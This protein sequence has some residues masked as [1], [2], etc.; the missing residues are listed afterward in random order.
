MRASNEFSAAKI[1]AASQKAKPKVISKFFIP[2]SPDSYRRASS[3]SPAE[4]AG[5]SIKNRIRPVKWF[6][7]PCKFF[8][9]NFYC[10]GIY[11]KIVENCSLARWH[12]YGKFGG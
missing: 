12:I 5:F 10:G 7:L 2:I 4:R 11:A 6:P 8:V 3:M 9:I 1:G